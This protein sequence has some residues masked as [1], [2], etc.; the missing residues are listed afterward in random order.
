[1]PITISGP[2]KDRPSWEAIRERLNPDTLGCLPEDWDHVCRNARQSD[3]PVW[4]GG[5]PTGFFGGPRELIGLERQV[6]MFYDEPDLMHEILDTLCDLWI[7]LYT[8]VQRDVHID[9]FFIW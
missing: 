9:W 4:A 1:M 3:E 2:V 5:L 7:S 6:M 8:R